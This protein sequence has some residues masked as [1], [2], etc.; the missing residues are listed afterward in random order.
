MI[1]KDLLLPFC[2]LFSV[3]LIGFFCSLSLFRLL[4]QKITDWVAYKQLEFISHSFLSSCL[5]NFPEGA[6]KSEI[7][8][9][10]WYTGNSGKNWFCHFVSNLSRVGWKAGHSS[11]LSMLQSWGKIT[12]CLWNCSF[13]FK[14]FNWMNNTHSHCWG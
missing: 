9:E 6:G 8:W 7:C 13:S 10:G 1:W 5:I 11:R 3:Y 12:F 2:S 4:Q 14:A